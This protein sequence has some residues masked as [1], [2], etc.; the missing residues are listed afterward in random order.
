MEPAIP[1][2]VEALKEIP[3]KTPQFPIIANSTAKFII[4]PQEIKEELISQLTSTV[5]WKDT[6][7]FMDQKGVTD[8]FEFGVV[9]K[10]VLSPMNLEAMKGS[11]E[12]NPKFP[13]AVWRRKSCC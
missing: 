4:T 1:F 3:I 2:V 7:D 10:P 9:E 12:K 6:I 13:I 8:I 5:L 11:V